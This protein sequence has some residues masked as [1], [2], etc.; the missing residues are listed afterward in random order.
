[1]K[2]CLKTLEALEK[3]KE[4]DTFFITLLK[5]QLHCAT[6]ESGRAF[7]WSKEVVHWALTLQFHGGKRIIED[8]RGKANATKGQHGDL[9]INMEE[10]G[11]FLPANSTLRNYLP[12]VEVYEGF[13]KENIENFKKAFPTGS[14]RKVIIAW[15]E[16]EIRYGLVW[17]PSTKELIGRVDGPIPEKEAKSRNWAKMNDGLATHVIQYFL[18]SADGAVSLPIGFHPMAAING[19]KVF[20]LVEPLF[21]VLKEGELALEVVATASDAFPSNKTLTELLNKNGYHSVHIFDP[22]HLLKSMRN[23]LWNQLLVKENIEFNLNTLDDLLKPS[24]EATTRRL[25]NSLHPGSPFPKDQMDLAPIRKLLSRELIRNLRERPEVH[26]QKLGEYLYNMRAFDQ[27]TTDNAMNNNERFRQLD[28]VVNYFKS[29]KNL[30]SGLVDQLS[31]TVKSINR[32]YDLSQ[33]EEGFEFRVSVLGT[34]V[35]E[36]F[37]STVR[38]KCRYPNLWEYGVFSRRAIFELIKQNA[39]DYLFIGPRKGQDQWKKYG[40]QRGIDFSIDQIK[41]MSKGEK[42]K[43]AESKRAKNGGSDEDLKFCQEKGREYRC[44]RKRMTVREIDKVKGLSLPLQDEDRDS[45]EMSSSSV[46]KELRVSG[47]SRQPHLW[48][49]L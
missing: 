21:K 25:F 11:M 24:A 45:C 33:T 23:N 31:T 37:F 36:N 46:P 12:P 20:K 39:D 41:L 7:R 43:M 40:N 49:A 28:Q 5:Q 6:K 47:Q 2:V 30:T 13:K 26:V 10:W 48:Q 1:M 35:V 34:I 44:K 16:I 17:N 14:P 19:E 3:S 42:K 27:A 32:V 9:E 22:L 18:I 38:A 8:L 29:L 15:D 4:K